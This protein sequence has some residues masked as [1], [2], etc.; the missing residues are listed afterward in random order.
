MRSFSEFSSL[1]FLCCRVYVQLDFSFFLH[2]TYTLSYTLL[3]VVNYYSSKFAPTHSFYFTHSHI[4]HT[5]AKQLFIFRQTHKTI[6]CVPLTV[7]VCV[8]SKF[9][10]L[11]LLFTLFS[12]ITVFVHIVHVRHTKSMQCLLVP[13]T[14]R[15][16]KRNCIYIS[17]D[18]NVRHNTHIGRPS[19]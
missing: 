17:L 3:A 12:R 7:H 8:C 18:R 15:S 19:D 14:Y 6:L 9:T 1:S 13:S 16:R 11:L 2:R 10:V 4:L 5:L